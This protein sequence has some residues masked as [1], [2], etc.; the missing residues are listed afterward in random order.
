MTNDNK[1]AKIKIQNKLSRYEMKKT[2]LSA[3]VSLAI[4]IAS[5][6]VFIVL[7]FLFPTAFEWLLIGKGV[8]TDAITHTVKNVSIAY[9]LAAPF[10]AAAL[11]MLIRLILNVL[12]GRIFVK[13][14]V[15]YLSLISYCCFAVFVISASF[16]YFYT[17]MLIAAF[18]MFVVGVLLRVVKNVMQSAVDL[19]NENDLTI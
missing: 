10:S 18:V 19:K 11:Y 1:S 2:K 3:Y 12:G 13:I 4:C 5:S 17:S 14:N 16:T 6:V 9:Y 7:L 15:T 8:K